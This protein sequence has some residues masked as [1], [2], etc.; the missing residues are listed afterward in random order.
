M[1]DN[2][3]TVFYSLVLGVVC[4]ALL[5]AASI[6]AEPYKKANARAAEERN[7][8]GVL[9]VPFDQNASAAQLSK[10]FEKN[11]RAVERGGQKI[12]EYV[13]DD[14]SR[15]QAVAVPFAGPGLWGPVKGFL[16][17]ESDMKTVR[18]VS[19]YEQEETPG[20]GGEIGSAWFQGQFKGKVI[21][22]PSG[23]PGLHVVRGKAAASNEV[24]GITGAT[25]TCDK[26]NAML[27]KLVKKI[28]EEQNNHGN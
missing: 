13:G 24:D 1:K 6:V 16:A 15:P 5:T 12:Y 10:T 23:Q 11:V 28:I 2:A 18:S 27:D 14:P 7:I 26:V 20:L 4:A 21:T 17:L 22:D 8:L 3:Y 19:F 9:E 25:M